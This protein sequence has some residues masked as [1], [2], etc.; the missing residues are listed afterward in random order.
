MSELMSEYK[1]ELFGCAPSDE[2]SQRSGRSSP[3]SL[4]PSCQDIS[5]VDIAARFHQDPFVSFVVKAVSAL[6]AAFRLVQLD[7]C[8]NSNLAS[9]LGLVRH[10]DLHQNILDNLRKL[11]F[12]SM[13]EKQR[14]HAGLDEGAETTEHFFAQNGRLVANKQLIFTIG[15]NEGL[16]QV[17]DRS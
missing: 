5:T 10:G 15:A 16:R 8:A 4:L 11:S 2:R 9:C 1:E 14:I 12:S 6:T 3:S 17:R 13:M 7:Q